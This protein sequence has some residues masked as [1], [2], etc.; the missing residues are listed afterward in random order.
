MST[1]ATSR[2][3]VARLLALV[4]YLQRRGEVSVAEAARDFGVSERTMRGDVKLL[5]Y[6]GLPGLGMGDLIELDF[7]ALK[8]E[9]LIRLSNAG[10]LTRPLR[11]DTTEAAALVVG[12]RALAEGAEPAEREVVVRALQKI[13]AAVGEAGGVAAQVELRP[14][15][16]PQ[17]QGLRER[18]TEA[19][20]AARQ[21]RL[22]HR[23]LTRDEV[24]ERVVDPIAVTSH[25]GRSYLDAW[26]HR[27][28]DRRLFR[29]DNVESAEVLEAPVT[30]HAALEPLDLSQ[31]IFRA[32]PEDLLA[33]LRLTSS[34]RW[35]SE[36]HP[37]E[38]VVEEPDGGLTVRMRVGDPAWLVR[39]VLQLGGAARLIEPE[40]LVAQV[41]S[42][43]TSVLGLY[44]EPRA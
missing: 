24:T 31:G 6:C 25:G 39:L 19:V 15:E 1:G 7:D 11:L 43:A 44:A 5:P 4:P 35:V 18:L 26:C 14:S 32:S 22:R 12:L 10:F 3:Q 40:E 13:Q 23:S 2:D 16:G 9:N 17:E 37:V 29:L 20:G 36:Y 38:S 21:V 34:A 28:Q 27:V 30:D 33:T 41:R 42:A 8:G